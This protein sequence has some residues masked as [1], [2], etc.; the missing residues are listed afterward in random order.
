MGGG[1]LK[2]ARICCKGVH[3][4]DHDSELHGVIMVLLT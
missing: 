3:K 1:R 4:D 2:R